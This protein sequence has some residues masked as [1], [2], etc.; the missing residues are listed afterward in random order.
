M[1]EPLT[2]WVIC[3][4][5]ALLAVAVVRQEVTTTSVNNANDTQQD[6]I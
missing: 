3:V 2:H 1:R 5:Q 6:I 4:T